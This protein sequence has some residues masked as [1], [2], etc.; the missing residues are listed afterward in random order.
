[1]YRQNGLDCEPS[2][3]FD[4]DEDSDIKKSFEKSSREICYRVKASNDEYHNHMA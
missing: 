2:S 3:F 1:M 4:I